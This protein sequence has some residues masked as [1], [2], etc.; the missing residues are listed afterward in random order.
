MKCK[1]KDCENNTTRISFI[2]CD[3]CAKTIT[4][5][6]FIILASDNKATQ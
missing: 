4:T 1:I 3:G 2:I 5:K 6:N